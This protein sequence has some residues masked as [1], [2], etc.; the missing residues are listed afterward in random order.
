MVNSDIITKWNE[1]STS[2]KS[3]A[4]SITSFYADKQNQYDYSFGVL[5][6]PVNRRK[7]DLF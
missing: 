5:I 3:L 4:S 1:I 7:T 6:N 2:I